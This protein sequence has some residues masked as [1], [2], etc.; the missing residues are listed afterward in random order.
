MIEAPLQTISLAQ[1]VEF[2][3]W[4]IQSAHPEDYTYSLLNQAP[5][6]DLPHPTDQVFSYRVTLK[7][8]TGKHVELYLKTFPAGHTK[9]FIIPELGDVALIE[10]GESLPLSKRSTPFGNYSN[11]IPV[12]L[13]ANKAVTIYSFHFNSIAGYTRT[14]K[15]F[16]HSTLPRL[17]PQKSYLQDYHEHRYIEFSMIAAMIALVLY[18]LIV[19][20]KTRHRSYIYYV[21]HVLS[22][23][24]YYL[25]QSQIGF[26][27]LWGEFPWFHYKGGIY[28][29]ALSALFAILFFQN[30]I[31]SK[32]LLPAWH[33]VL[34][35][36]SYTFLIVVFALI[37]FQLTKID[38]IKQYLSPF[39]MALTLLSTSVILFVT[40]LAIRKGSKDAK[41]Y[42]FTTLILI[43]S[44][45]LFLILGSLNN[46]SKS[47]ILIGY[48]SQS[49][50]LSFGLANSINNLEEEISRQKLVQIKLKQ[51]QA[52]EKQL[53]LEE[54]KENL[55][56]EVKKRTAELL[57]TNDEL[58]STVNQL[59]D[60][61]QQLAEQRK[62]L[63][64][65]NR[66][67]TS[68][69]QY[70]QRIQMA[71]LPSKD[72]MH[73]LLPQS[74][75]LHLPRDIVSGDFYWFGRI[76]A[77]TIVIAAD[78]TGHG[79]PGA[80]MSLIGSKLL[81]H[82]IL[83][84]GIT[85]PSQILSHLDTGVEQSLNSG[86]SLDQQ[87]NDG[88][89]IAVCVI[90]PTENKLYFAGAHN[91][92]FIVKKDGETVLIKGDKLPIGSAQH[93]RQK[94][95]TSHSYKYTYGDTFYLYSDGFYDQFGGNEGRKYYP[96]N[97]KKC[98]ANLAM[99][100]IEEQMSRLSDEFNQWKGE[101]AQVDDV[102]VIGVR[103]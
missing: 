27:Y 83:E 82:I 26:E 78:S 91:P 13:P 94:A 12:E 36:I 20:F 39:N 69:I 84:K 96:K 72:L 64:G 35:Y 5:V 54:Q 92:I 67:I 41:F 34:T 70:A 60:A 86:T 46:F 59:N 9:T 43:V 100:P 19:F 24:F 95:F 58:Y 14:Y 73:Y 71:S 50:L 51:Q 1:D 53:M 79:V 76:E 23:V 6:V 15:T 77:K 3:D 90:D 18:N 88:M 37:F 16:P 52:K 30:F 48:T 10:I 62:Y 75:V 89:D 8:N 25:F 103:L 22:F 74:F 33:K 29:S 93:Y 55:K 98:L 7:N 40:I 66:K 85:E 17:I 21:L 56:S 11:L 45:V 47:L 32:T 4:Q 31:R 38:S 42:L 68:S 102:L 57:E 101:H 49:L 63:E 2:L 44:V 81:D 65:V 80:F 97:F 87:M 99:F 61:N 28:F